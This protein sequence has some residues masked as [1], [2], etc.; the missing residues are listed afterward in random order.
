MGPIRQSGREHGDVLMTSA[1][2]SNRSVRM[3]VTIACYG[4][5]NLELLERVIATY[6][7]MP[8]DVDIVV[9]SES[10]K[11]L[12]PDVRVVV[13]L[14]AKNPWSLP[15]AHKAILAENLERYDL[16]VYSEDD[17][18]VTTRNVQ[19]F[20]E[21]STQ[22]AADEIAGFLRYEVGS[23]GEWSLP[24]IHGGYHWIAESARQRGP[25]TVAE[26]SNEHAAFYVLTQAQLKTAIESGG[27]LV[28]PHEG[29]YDM[30]CSAA[31]DPYT[32]CGFR[33]V[34]CVSR[35]DDFLI[36][37]LSDRYAGRLGVTLRECRRHIEALTNI[38]SKQRPAVSFCKSESALLHGTW[39]KS[40][41]EPADPTLLSVVPL[42]AKTVLSIGCGQGD[43]ESALIQK[44]MAVTAIPLD[45]V[46]GQVAERRGIEIT[47]AALSDGLAALGARMFDCVVCTDLLHLLPDPSGFVR[48]CGERVA[49]GGAL[50]LS[51]PN[52]RSARIVVKRLLGYRDYRLLAT[53]GGSGVHALSASDGIRFATRSGLRRS[54]IFWYAQKPLRQYL[55]PL[56]SLATGRWIVRAFH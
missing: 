1:F 46:I 26:F 51:G 12:A 54:E 31:T 44:G 45:S 19:S 52:L 15:F 56:Q 39:S 10:P 3:L 40:Y 9:V 5:R 16:F 49:S 7:A 23:D 28:S 36:H 35:L 21:V 2:D 50:L 29:R 24:E 55:Y 11:Q 22:L 8:F 14:P 27:F 17:M 20:L 6:Q 37:H 48:Q 43:F 18:E 42:G 38:A 41:Y 53:Y 34:V 30:L 32:N 47:N 33:K 25:L 13:G 4:T